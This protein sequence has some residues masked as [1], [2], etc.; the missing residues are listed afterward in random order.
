[1]VFKNKKASSV[2]VRNIKGKITV[3]PNS[4]LRDVGRARIFVNFKRQLCHRIYLIIH[5]QFFTIKL[6]GVS[7][8]EKWF[9][10]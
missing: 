10:G 6:L 7:G 2:H 4:R 5:Y 3:P 9:S 8:L 1:M